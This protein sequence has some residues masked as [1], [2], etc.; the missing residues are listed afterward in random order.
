[1]V[2]TPIVPARLGQLSAFLERLRRET[3]DSM[4]GSP[5][6]HPLLDWASLRTVHYAR[7]VIVAA[8]ERFGTGPLLAFSTSYDGPLGQPHAGRKGAEQAHIRELAE[9]AGSA[10]DTI[11]RCCEGYSG[12]NN[13]ESYLARHRQSAATFYVGSSGRPRDQVLA[14]LALRTRVHEVLDELY[15]KEPALEPEAVR[16]RVLADPIIQ[17]IRVPT[18]PAQPNRTWRFALFVGGLVPVLVAPVAGLFSGVLPLQVV[19]ASV[20]GTLGLAVLWFRYREDN[21]PEYEP[22]YA[23]PER[24][25]IQ[26]ASTDEDVFLQNQLTHL[27]DVKPGM[28]RQ[29][30][31]RAVFLGLQQLAR[32]IYNKG[33]L[34]SIPSIHFARWCLIDGG[35]RLIFFSNFDNSWESYL[36]DFI[37]QASSGLT[38]I[39]SNT[40]EYPST[41]WLVQ[42]GA[43]DAG[44]FKAWTR[45]Y[46]VRTQVWYSAYPQLSIRNLNA[47]TEIRRGL[48]NP[49]QMP[50][51]VWL[52]WLQGIDRKAADELYAREHAKSTLGPKPTRVVEQTEATIALEEVQGLILHGYGPRTGAQFLMLRV[53]EDKAASARDWLSRLPLT[54]AVRGNKRNAAPDP[55]INVAF[56]HAGLKAL[57]L[58]E[59][60]LDE[61]PAAFVEGS[62]HARRAVINGDLGESDPHYWRW[63]SGSAEPHVL[64]L[65]YATTPEIALAH[66]SRLSDEAEREG[67]QSVIQLEGGELTGRKEHF[68]FRDGIAQPAVRGCGRPEPVYNSV[69][70]GE[71]LLGHPDE[72]GNIAHCPGGANDGFG[73]NGS[74]LVFRQLEQDVAAFWKYCDEQAARLRLDPVT[75]A[76]KLVG[77]WPSGASLVKHPKADPESEKYQD[78]DAFAYLA[79]GSDNDRSGHSCPFGSHLR[80]TNP[81]DW[82]SGATRREAITIANRHRIIR[83]GRPYGTPAVGITPPE[84]LESARKGTGAPGKRGLQFLAFSADL[85]RQ[86]EFV[87]QQWSKNPAF[88]GLS[89]GPDA[90]NG[91]AGA[92]W[93]TSERG[94]T[95]QGDATRSS[96]GRCTGLSHFVKLIGSAYFFMPSVPAVRKLPGLAAPPM[97]R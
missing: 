25:H 74:Y 73:A 96:F 88:A 27:V 24:E 68:G 61:F 2:L 75:I 89:L 43:E 50:A 51:S 33:K 37:D 30:L 26:D 28:L 52:D 36:G 47:N 44:R 91:G 20:L 32:N 65:V 11:Y 53:H 95:I 3:L 66:T 48:A 71:F 80:R 17:G 13:L 69:A 57:G 45:H 78:E 22:V 18:F 29:L 15:V 93:N 70:P 19:S 6:E 76:A 59:Q 34:G 21:D 9:V 90:I 49:E 94:F 62:A 38:A 35:R 23:R 14:E 46:Q 63:G 60:L 58:R 4:Q 5:P 83:R 16:R 31:I 41:R 81:R 12:L 54:D 82:D 97:T 67:L 10:L 1:L 84:L 56:T 39:W 92:E 40:V 72:Y 55:F 64:I 42:A 87:Q 85:E 8:C 7:F 86:F 79:D 77:R